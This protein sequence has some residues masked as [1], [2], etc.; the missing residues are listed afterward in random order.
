MPMKKKLKMC[1]YPAC[2]KG[3][4]PGKTYNVY[5]F[6]VILSYVLEKTYKM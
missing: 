4:Y 6:H 1:K 3:Y 5:K 2:S